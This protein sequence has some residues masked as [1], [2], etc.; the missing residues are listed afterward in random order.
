MP[1]SVAI[2]KYIY[3]WLVKW[4]RGFL[5]ETVRWIRFEAKVLGYVLPCGILKGHVWISSPL[6]SSCTFISYGILH[7][8]ILHCS[9]SDSSILTNSEN[10]FSRVNAHSAPIFT[11]PCFLKTGYLQS[12][13]F[14]PVLSAWFG[15]HARGSPTR[16]S[17]V[18]L[19]RGLEPARGEWDCAVGW[20]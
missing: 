17:A 11:S 13:L 14:L 16:L 7:S 4:Y 6:L 1:W 15:W 8:H 12:T 3:C 19:Y 2:P 18:H 9:P 20:D 5:Y 10:G